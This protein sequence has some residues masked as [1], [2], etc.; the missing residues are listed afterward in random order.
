[1][2][3][4][5]D[6]QNVGQCLT[7]ES[8]TFDPS[9][10]VVQDR[11][12]ASHF[13]KMIVRMKTNVTTDDMLQVFWKTEQTPQFSEENSVRVVVRPSSD[14]VEYI[15]PLKNSPGWQGRVTALRFDPVA[16]AGIK[17]EIEHLRLE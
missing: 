12:R 4:V 1:M 5:K 16:T 13:E 8:T 9:I 17:V 7:F 15:V 14:F 6:F 2:Q 11:S 10:S 3:N